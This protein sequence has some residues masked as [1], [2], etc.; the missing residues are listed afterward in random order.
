MLKV[1]HSNRMEALVDHLC[2][3]L[4]TPLSSPL[5]AE[6]MV[7]QNTGLARWLNLRLAERFGIAGNNDYLMPSSFVW[8]LFRDCLG[9]VPETSPFDKELLLWRLFNGLPDYLDDEA[10]AA[11][12]DYLADDDN[13]LKRYQLARRI[14]D[15]FDQYL[16]YRPEWVLA[17][18]SGQDDHWQARLWRDLAASVGGEHRAALQQ[19]F[20]RQDLTDK[21]LPERVCVFGISSLAPMSLDVLRHLAEFT[22]VVFFVLN[23]SLAYWGDILP[24]K[25]LLKLKELWRRSGRETL[26]DYVESGNPLLADW[27]RLGRDFQRLLYAENVPDEIDAFEPP[28][29]DHLLGMLQSDLLLLQDR[30]EETK[31]PIPTDDRSLQVHACHSPLREVEVL[32]DQLLDL[33]RRYPDLRPRDVV[34]MTPDIDRYA[35][36]V[37]AV[38]GSVPEARNI[39]WSLADL[40]VRSESPLVEML[41]QLLDLPDSRFTAGEILGL[42]EIEE[43][44][45]RFAIEVSDLP[46]LRRWVGEAGIRWGRG[47]G[48]LDDLNSWRTGFRRLF[49]GFA[50]PDGVERYDDTAP[51][52]GPEGAQAAV[53]GGLKS[54]LDRLDDTADRFAADH[55]PKRWQA[56]LNDALDGLLDAGDDNP[57][58]DRIREALEQLAS[59]SAASADETADDPLV[60]RQV[61][62]AY[63]QNQLSA[64]GAQ[65][66][67][68]AGKV[69]FCAMVPMRAVPFRVV[70]LLG[71][72]D[73]DYPRRA[74]RSGFDLMVGDQRPGD[75]SVR[76]EDRHLFLEALLSA[77]DCLLLSYVGADVRDNSELQPS[78]VLSEL[79]DYVD[80]GFERE[81]P[82]VLHHPLQPFSRRYGGDE[83]GVFSYA[84]E[85]ALESEAAGVESPFCPQPLAEPEVEFHVVTLEQLESF[86]AHPARYFLR[87]RMGVVFDDKDDT[88]EDDEN[89]EL[90]FLDLYQKRQELLREQLSGDGFDER[91]ELY[92][93]RGE[94]PHGAFGDHLMADERGPIEQLADALA[95]FQPKPDQ[96]VD[97]QLNDLHLQGWLSGI[98][99]QGLTTWRVTGFNGKDMIRL[100]LRHLMLNSLEGEDLPRNSLHL[101]PES[102]TELPPMESREQAR[103]T[104][105]RVLGIYWRG[106]SRP[107]HFFPKTSYVYAAHDGDPEKALGK[108]RNTW[109]GNSFTGAAGE[110]DD[111][112]YQ[113]AFRGTEPFDDE[114]SELADELFGSALAMIDKE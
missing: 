18:E 77:R 93:L 82:L 78:L 91:A 42:L 111:A 39:P 92:R 15:V 54:L 25:S 23:P 41:V 97:L 57:S 10:F 108:A 89:F 38:F 61:V 86:Y 85:W 7:V 59:T 64:A 113:A 99:D 49:F 51:L 72:N 55:S 4:S 60:S 74:R 34:V 27:G 8:R 53:L 28:P 70:A 112:Y 30:R 75:R 68:A 17:W 26:P 32:H 24:E 36:Y 66:R 84:V 109:L 20:L 103:E 11:L 107:L 104:L 79:L 105:G 46:L 2:H 73:R 63:L 80:D 50:L 19:R 13:G 33:F 98:T 83:P 48:D 102:V 6:K 96:E 76:D 90:E 21:P 14:A 114:F 3:V 88:P 31:Q 22:D 5:A 67:Y 100:W 69:T 110:G 1:I 35:P 106:L 95:D 45:K 81:T 44:R 9:D 87:R 62:K 65:H 101:T 12:R 58:L 71:L 40:S 94:L 16:V 29:E 56:L 43:L 37:Q 47:D 52:E